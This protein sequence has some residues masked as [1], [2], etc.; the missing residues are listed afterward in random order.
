MQAAEKLIAAN[1]IGNVSIKG[2]VTAAG[3]KN[4]SALQYHFTNIDG[5]IKAIHARRSAQIQAERAAQ[6]AHRG[7]RGAP[8]SLR[9]ICRLMVEPAFVL[10]KGKPDFRRYVKAFGH[11]IPLTD[12]PA[13][14]LVSRTGGQGAQQVGEWLRRA[15]AHLDDE[16]F[17]QR[18]DGAVRFIGA[19]MFHQAGRKDAFRG[20]QAEFF[21]HSL[22]D[23]LVGLLCAAESD[24]TR[25]AAASMRRS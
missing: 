4:E 19:S 22:I 2:I 12:R 1:G 15:L 25:A 3:Q 23:A 20:A 8:A 13:F 9:E 10:A 11:E 24:E 17:E 14:A 5:L 21:F 7:D 16:A 6:L 18:I